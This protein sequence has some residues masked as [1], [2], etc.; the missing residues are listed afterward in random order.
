M[1]CH[2]TSYLRPCKLLSALINQL[3][4]ADLA[5]LHAHVYTSSRCTLPIASYFYQMSLQCHGSPLSTIS[6]RITDWGMERIQ[7]VH[8][9]DYL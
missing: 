1:V 6:K 9:V 7:Y 2:A 3:L 4:H 5:L 8:V